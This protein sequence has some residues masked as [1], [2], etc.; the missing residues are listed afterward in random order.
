[1]KR[2]VLALSY[3]L[4]VAGCEMIDVE[5]PIGLVPADNLSEEHAEML[6]D[7]AHCWNLQFG[8]QFEVSR[9]STYDQ[10][11][12][13]ELNEGICGYAGGYTQLA[14]PPRVAV[15]P[16]NET[17]G[18]AGTFLHELG[19]VLN[20]IQH[21]QD[22][23][24]N[25]GLTRIPLSTTNYEQD[26]GIPDAFSEQDKAAFWDANPGAKLN[27]GCDVHIASSRYS[28]GDNYSKETPIKCFCR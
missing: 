8:T 20:I 2:Q 19:H 9:R 21:T 11:V 12:S 27:P 6:E 7:A 16:S 24:M 15:C 13:V 3:V 28:Y 1:M 14:P 25:S 17:H 5:K 4:F 23:V 10:Q 26:T 22:G 18:I